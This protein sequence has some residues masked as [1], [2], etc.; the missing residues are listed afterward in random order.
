MIGL[1]SIAYDD[2]SSTFIVPEGGGFGVA[3]C[4]EG[5]SSN[6]LATLGD[7]LRA[8]A[9]RGYLDQAQLA[10]T[11]NITYLE[12]SDS[13]SLISRGAGTASWAFLAVVV[14]LLIL[15]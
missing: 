13:V 4:P 11:Q 8:V 6:I 3:F 9:S 2:Q 15:F 5:R 12:S 7:Q 10:L 1:I 14:A